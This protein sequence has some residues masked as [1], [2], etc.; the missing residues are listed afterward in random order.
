MQFV[1]NYIADPQ[2]MARGLQGVRDPVWEPLIDTSC[3]LSA[4]S[5]EHIPPPSA[6]N[7]WAITALSLFIQSS[8]MFFSGQT[9]LMSVSITVSL[10]LPASHPDCK[11]TSRERAKLCFRAT[12]CKP[13]KGTPFRINKPHQS[14]LFQYMVLNE[15]WFLCVLSVV[16]SYLRCHKEIHLCRP[17]SG[18]RTGKSKAK[19]YHCSQICSNVFML[20]CFVI[21]SC[22]RT[23]I[24]SHLVSRRSGS[25]GD[26]LTVVASFK[27]PL[28][29]L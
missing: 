3:C 20:T 1:A 29:E 5:C 4:F 24:I 28:E 11:L 16:S 27:W 22:K 13:H 23:V 26:W 9:C 10:C 17:E 18:K 19:C 15:H 8:H 7:T 14:A 2:A 6:L 12:R 21:S 25:H